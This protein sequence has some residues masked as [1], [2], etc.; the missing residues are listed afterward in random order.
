MIPIRHGYALFVVLTVMT[1]IFILATA[2]SMNIQLGARQALAISFE[3]EALNAADSGLQLGLE[4]VRQNI[5]PRLP[6]S[7]DTALWSLLTNVNQASACFKVFVEAA[8]PA[9]QV[10]IKSVGEVVEGACGDEAGNLSL[11]LAARAIEGSIDLNSLAIVKW[12]EADSR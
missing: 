1:L 7:F 4:A 2:F 11:I 10:C 12:N 9:N 3:A 6:V 8:C 5:A